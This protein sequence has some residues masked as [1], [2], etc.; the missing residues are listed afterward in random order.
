[1]CQ[2]NKVIK[3]SNNTINVSAQSTRAL[4]FCS[5]DVQAAAAFVL[6][7]RARK[8]QRKTEDSRLKHLRS[9]A[10]QYGRTPNGKSVDMEAV[11]N[12]QGM[13]YDR[14][15]CAEALRQVC[16]RVWGLGDFLYLTVLNIAPLFSENVELF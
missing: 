10:E 14:S 1:M 12:L 3:F 7:Q 8:E 15:L 4:R 5:G 13:G 2:F 9:E 6:E 16:W 11:E